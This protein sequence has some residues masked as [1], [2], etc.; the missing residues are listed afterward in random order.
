ME[1]P[2]QIIKDVF[3]RFA[4]GVTVI[5]SRHGDEVHGMTASAVSS[6]SLDPPLLLVSVDHRA[7]MCDFLRKAGIFTVNV[8]TLEQEALS[9]RFASRGPKSLDDIPQDKSFLGAPVFSEC[10]AYAEC[11]V[12]HILP[13]GDHDIFVGEVV[14]GKGSTSGVPLLYYQGK[15]RKLADLT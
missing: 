13:G 3:G 15:Y 9:N 14:A 12:R 8:L 6:L 2:A 5:T 4:T 10:L 1:N 7:A 11:R